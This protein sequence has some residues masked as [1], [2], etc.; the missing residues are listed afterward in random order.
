[1]VA[2]WFWDLLNSAGSSGALW[3][4]VVV[5]LA[6]LGE[7][8][9]PFTCPV[10]EGIL[11]FYGFL[12]AHG[13]PFAGVA[14]FLLAA[15]AGR[16]LGAT[17]VYGVSGRVGISVL[18]RY[19]HRLKL[20]PERVA[21]LKER[22]AY[23]VV[24]T[25]ILARFTPG[26]TVLTSFLSGVSRIDPKRFLACVAGQIAIWEGA[27]MA[28]GALGAAASRSFDPTDY[29]RI[30]AIIIGTTISLS[31]VVGYAVLRRALQR[32]PGVRTATGATH[33]SHAR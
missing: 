32:T 17:T 23:L 12:L 16:F 21:L 7:L 20:T 25:I 29:P 26:F 11:V 22:L 28:A 3:L 19:G 33:V 9:L 5:V 15:L 24:P 14:P 8:G 1:M 31:A 27:F 4:S 30:L 10:M 13:S 6:L 18:T 2:Q